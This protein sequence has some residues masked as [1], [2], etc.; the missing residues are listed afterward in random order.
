MDQHVKARLTKVLDAEGLDALVATTPENLQYVTGFRS[1]A[2]ALF[3]GLE[4]YG[5]FTRQGVGLVIPFIDSTGVSADGIEVD[6]I[7]CYGN[8]FF[9]YTDEPG[10]IATRVREITSRPAAG[11]GEALREV[12][13]GFGVTGRRIAVDEAGVFPATW[14][15]LG[16]Q[17]AGTTIAPAYAHFRTARMVKSPV[18]VARLEKAAR[19]A[20]D[21]IAAIWGMLKAGVTERE[22]ASAF[23]Q[24]V[25]RRGAQ[26]FFTVVTIGP[27]RAALADVYAS[28]TALKA[29]DLVRLDLGCVYQGYRSDISRTAVLGTPTEK[30]RRY[31]DAI[32]DGEKAA[33][34]AMKPGMPVSQI[35][36]IG[37][38]VTREAGMPHY[39]RNHVGHGIGLEPYDPP[40][41]NA[42]GQTVLEPGMVF[43]VETPY[44]EHGWGGIQVEDAVE[45]TAAGVRRL[46]Q[47]SQELQILG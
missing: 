19:I 37:M 30:Q 8:F 27:H 38:K 35:F 15:R 44:Y 18:E 11:P 39:Q 20:E 6:R 47:S 46:T 40:T 3:R 17:L 32:R 42:A 34:A 10:P 21:G 26:T 25:I 2:H 41:I 13:G 4:L 5:V 28:E 23:E 33:I 29:G 14:Q 1:I 43:C 12:L 7:A 22:A 31:Y 16:E 36:E 24:E 45:I 9:N